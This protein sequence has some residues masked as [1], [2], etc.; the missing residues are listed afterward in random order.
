MQETKVTK[1]PERTMWPNKL[2]A[3]HK[4]FNKQ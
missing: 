2:L 1:L 4:S 3:K